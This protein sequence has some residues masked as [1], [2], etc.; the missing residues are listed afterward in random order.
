M[1]ILTILRHNTNYAVT[2]VL[3]GGRTGARRAEVITNLG[4]TW[5]IIYGRY[6]IAK[7]V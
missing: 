1:Q 4:Y 2:Y 5:Y 6:A 3:G 7:V